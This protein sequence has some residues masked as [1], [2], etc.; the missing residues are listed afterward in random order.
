MYINKKLN[1]FILFISLIIY[2]IIKV[3]DNTIL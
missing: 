2:F 3:Y 1:Y